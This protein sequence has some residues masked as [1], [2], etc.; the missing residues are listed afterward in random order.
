MEYGLEGIELAIASLLERSEA[1][2][3]PTTRRAVHEDLSATHTNQ[4]L[5]P[6]PRVHAVFVDGHGFSPMHPRRFGEEERIRIAT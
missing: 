6:G 1:Q 5:Q 3:A 2:V 4:L